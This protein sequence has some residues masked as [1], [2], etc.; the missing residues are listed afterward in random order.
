MAGDEVT[1]ETL[2]RALPGVKPVSARRQFVNL[3]DRLFYIVAK[4]LA[5]LV[6]VLALLLVADLCRGASE[7][8]RQM[9]IGDGVPGARTV[10][11]HEGIDIERVDAD[12]DPID[13]G[14]ALRALAWVTHRQ[15]DEKAALAKILEILNKASVLYQKAKIE[16]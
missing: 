5:L 4:S 6:I 16:D 8:I 2:N 9:L 3:G 13:L 10:T 7:A 11:V 14:H 1:L 15:G 12:A